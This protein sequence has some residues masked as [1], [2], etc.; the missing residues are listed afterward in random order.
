MGL[1]KDDEGKTER[2]TPDRLR[3]ARNRGQTNISREFTMAGSLLIAVLTIEYLGFW[4]MDAFEQLMRWG[5]DVNPERHYLEDGEVHGAVTEIERVME[6]LASPYI[7]IVGIFVAA[8]ML[9]GY[10]QIGFKISREALVFRPEKLNPATNL[11]KLFKF[12]SV[13]K[14]LFSV[15]KLTVLG[16]VLYLVIYNRLADLAALYEAA[17]FA[18]AVEVIM[19]SR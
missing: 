15:A 10:G 13:F 6:I 2:A 16:G 4:L 7:V 5:M 17:S 3:Q 11:G 12:S 19:A 8:T 1:F 9:F 18:D 14:T